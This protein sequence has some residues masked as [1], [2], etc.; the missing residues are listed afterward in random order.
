MSDIKITQYGRESEVNVRIVM[1]N[2][3]IMDHFSRVGRYA[4]KSICL[5]IKFR[6]LLINKCESVDQYK[7]NG[8]YNYQFI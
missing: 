3:I 5:A 4:D 6:V 2:G 1:D 8:K 7:K